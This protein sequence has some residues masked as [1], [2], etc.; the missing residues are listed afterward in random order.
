MN[1]IQQ[2]KNKISAQAT[3]S[4]SSTKYLVIKNTLSNDI[5]F[6]LWSATTNIDHICLQF[7][8]IPNTTT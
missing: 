2:E 6:E 3:I 8:A 7:F 1:K 4:S 5:V